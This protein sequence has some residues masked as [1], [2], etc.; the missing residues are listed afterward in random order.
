MARMMTVK[1]AAKRWEVSERRIGILC[2]EGRIP[3]A[4]KEGRRW[5]IPVDAE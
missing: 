1:E 5:L 4:Y 3:G 2:Q